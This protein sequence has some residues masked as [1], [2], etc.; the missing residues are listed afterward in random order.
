[1]PIRTPVP[2]RSALVPF[3]VLA[4]SCAITDP[5]IASDGVVRR[6]DVEGGC[7]TIEADGARL[8]PI[9]LPTEFRVDGLEIAFEANDRADLVTTCQVG[10]IV[11]LDFIQ[12][13]QRKAS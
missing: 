6:L 8:E 1:M 10:R 2:P 9:N 11:E 5:D 3:F 13:A 4:G 7:W 12:V